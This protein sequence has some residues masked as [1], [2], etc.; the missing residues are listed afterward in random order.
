MKKNAVMIVSDA[1][2]N[3]F[4]SWRK[5]RGHCGNATDDQDGNRRHPVRWGIF[6]FPCRMHSR[7]PYVCLVAGVQSRVV[8]PHRNEH[9]RNCP[10]VIFNQPRLD[11]ISFGC[12]F[13]DLNSVDEV[14]AGFE[15]GV[16]THL[17]A[18]VN[19]FLPLPG[20]GVGSTSRDS[21]G[22]CFLSSAEMIAET[23]SDGGV[24]SRNPRFCGR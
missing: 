23:S 13:A 19:S 15:Y 4:V 17:T 2:R 22:D 7:N 20:V 24:Q 21:L 5:M 11:L 3:F 1:A 10:Y 16:D 14:R 6:L 12:K 9:L 18:E 8:E